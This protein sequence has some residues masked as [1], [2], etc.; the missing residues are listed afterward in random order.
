MQLVAMEIGF[1]EAS[2][3]ATG[4]HCAAGPC[5]SVVGGAWWDGLGMRNGGWELAR[6]GWMDD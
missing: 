6:L 1:I 3:R 4:F 5:I 2:C